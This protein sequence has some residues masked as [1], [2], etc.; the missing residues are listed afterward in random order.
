MSD[1]LLI[2]PAG[3]IEYPAFNALINDGAISTIEIT[4][5]VDNQ[6]WVDLDNMLSNAVLLPEGKN[7][8]GSKLIKEDTGYRVWFTF[9]P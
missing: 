9:Y 1:F 2:I 3:W 6:Q 7:V 5:A 4:N 8:T